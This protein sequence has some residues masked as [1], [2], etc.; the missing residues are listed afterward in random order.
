MIHVSTGL[1]VKDISRPLQS[2]PPGV[3]LQASTTNPFISSFSYHF[4]SQWISPALLCSR[5]WCYFHLKK[6]SLCTLKIKKKACNGNQTKTS[7]HCS[8]EAGLT[9]RCLSVHTC[10]VYSCRVYC[11]LH[12]GI[13][14]FHNRNSRI[15][16]HI[17]FKIH[18]ISI[19]CIGLVSL[20]WIF[21]YKPS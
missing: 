7:M 8:V 12:G 3:G 6:K 21:S 20:H 18:I 5:F 14:S 15:V 16:W 13:S 11:T 1:A 4:L 2:P 10:N 17:W 19:Q 9:Y